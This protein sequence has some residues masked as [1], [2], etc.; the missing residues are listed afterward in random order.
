M[1]KEI[2]PKALGVIALVVIVAGGGATYWQYTAVSTAKTK[3][4]SIQ[5]EI[6]TE[7]ELQQSLVDSGDKLRE[8]TEKVQ[9]LEEGVP[10][11]AYIPTLMK[12]LEKVGVDLDI[13]VIGVRPAPQSFMGAAKDS[14][15][16]KDRAYD[17][18]EIEVTIRGLYDDSKRFL[19]ALE[20]FA[21]IIAVK[22]VNMKPERAMGDGGSDQIE[23]TIYVSVYVFPFEFT[24]PPADTEES[25]DT[26]GTT[27]ASI[28]VGAGS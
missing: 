11:I 9:H 8:Y 12:E 22:K 18:I 25:D 3:I 28:Q 17:E 5:A 20:Q 15:A 27:V 10:D 2:N 23:T 24:A 16:D 26:E 1:S 4:A 7:R 6:P 14:G 19:D 13:D 21:K